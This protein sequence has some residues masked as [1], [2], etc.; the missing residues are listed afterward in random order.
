[1]EPAKIQ[2]STAEM[3]L[4]N[5]AN[6][7]LTKNKVQEKIRLLFEEAQLDMLCFRST[8]PLFK[9][10]PKISRGEN[11]SGLPYMVLD[12]P[13]YFSGQDIG[14]FRSMFWWGNFFSSTLHLSGSVKDKYVVLIQTRQEDLAK[15]GYYIGINAD[16]WQHHFGNDNYRLIKDVSNKDFVDYCQGLSHLKIAAKWP[17]SGQNPGVNETL[18]HWYFFL[19]LT[20]LIAS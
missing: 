18:K 7:I 15:A 5:N 10:P 16:P 19:H 14:L 4:M 1:M 6:I 2:F 9:L 8:D 3:E 13:R 12:Y 17:L 20:G 11:Y